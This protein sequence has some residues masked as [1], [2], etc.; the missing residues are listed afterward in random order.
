MNE[1]KEYLPVLDRKAL[2]LNAK[3]LLSDQRTRLKLIF[4][5][6][7]CASVYI[8]LEYILSYAV[9]TPVYM[10]FPGLDGWMEYVVEQACFVIEFLLFSPLLL[11]L[12]SLA[13]SLSYRT[14]IELSHIFGYYRSFV[15]M[16]RAWGIFLA[17][18]LPIKLFAVLSEVAFGLLSSNK[19]GLGNALYIVLIFA[20]VIL[21]VGIFAVGFLI[22]GKFFPFVYASV[23]AKNRPLSQAFGDSL[24][25]TSGKLGSIFAF[26]FSFILLILLS[27]AT[28]GVL[29]IIYTIPYMAVSYSYCS[30]YLLTGEYKIIDV[31]DPY[32]E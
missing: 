15:R 10:L 20:A 12:Y 18:A 8:M 11:G 26:R 32:Y 19:E 30:S 9:Y 5:T 17:V 1:R 2:K 28:V 14:D 22:C 24:R 13:A 21:F 6:L 27:F 25:A 23:T 16:C 31:E 7:I 3:R 4:A 29:F